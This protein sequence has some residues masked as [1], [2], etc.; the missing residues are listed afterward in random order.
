MTPFDALFLFCLFT[1]PIALIHGVIWLLGFV[2]PDA[3]WIKDF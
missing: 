1:T 3:Q 2:Y